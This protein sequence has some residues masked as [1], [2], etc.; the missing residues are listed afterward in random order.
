MCMSRRQPTMVQQAPAPA[1]ILP[2]PPPPAMPV[3]LGLPE[4]ETQFGIRSLRGSAWR[5]NLRIRSAGGSLNGGAGVGSVPGSQPIAGANR[6]FGSKSGSGST[7]PP[8]TPPVA[9]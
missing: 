7:P 3:A 5:S 2:P 8:R 1:P 4:D 9:G 6:Y